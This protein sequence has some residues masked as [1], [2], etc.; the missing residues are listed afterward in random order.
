ML[1]NV[2]RGCFGFMSMLGGWSG[3]KGRK[4]RSKWTGSVLRLLSVET[5]I[6]ENLYTQ[7]WEKHVRESRDF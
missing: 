5:Y 2:S 1:S 7:E 3:C 4:E 6:S